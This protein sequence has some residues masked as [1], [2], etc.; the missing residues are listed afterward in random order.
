M[1]PKETATYH[2]VLIA[3]SVIGTII[4][5]FIISVIRY[6]RSNR[7]RFRN[8]L[9]AE[10]TLLEKERA[11]IAADLH[12]ELG[13][14]LSAVKFKLDKI[15]EQPGSNKAL[16]EASMQYIDNILLQVRG[17]AYGLMPITLIRNGLVPALEEFITQTAQNS[18]LKIHFRHQNLPPLSPEISIH[19]YRILQE[20][21]HNTVKHAFATRLNISLGSDNKSVIIAAADDGDGFNPANT[22]TVPGIG[23]QSLKNRTELLSGDIHIKSAPGKGTSIYIEIPLPETVTNEPA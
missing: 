2:A 4:L 14:L 23:L 19:L 17:I 5:Y 22:G 21:I 1:D 10:I 7:N 18:S 11:R 13:P 16:A 15:D 3:A 12:D 8:K 20:L 9:H 6:Q